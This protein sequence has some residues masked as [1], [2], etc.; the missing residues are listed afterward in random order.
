VK[1]KYDGSNNNG[2]PNEPMFKLMTSI[3][4]EI[5][6]QLKDSEGYLN[7]G[8]ETADGLR[9]IFFACSDF[10]KPSKVLYYAQQEFNQQIEFDYDIYKDKYWQT[11]NRFTNN[12]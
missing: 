12:N 3:E 9:E 4:E 6:L 10:R 2:M 5:M 8:R 7:I 11:F 1:L